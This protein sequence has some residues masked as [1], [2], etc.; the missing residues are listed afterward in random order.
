VSDQRRLAGAQKPGDD[1]GG[2][3][4]HDWLFPFISTGIPA[5]TNTTRSAIAA[6]D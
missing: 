2:N 4:T 3:F 5:V 6:M 1:G